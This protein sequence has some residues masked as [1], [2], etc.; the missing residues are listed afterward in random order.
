MAQISEYHK[1]IPEDETAYRVVD[2]I[3]KI[4][5]YEKEEIEC[6]SRYI[7][8]MDIDSLDTVELL[9]E[10]EA[11]FDLKIS[12]EDAKKLL[13]V[14]QTIRYIQERLAEKVEA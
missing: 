7:Q 3:S 12:D 1:T 13:T 9:L 14:G 8:D 4:I 11:E 5:G 2:I 6:S 10:L